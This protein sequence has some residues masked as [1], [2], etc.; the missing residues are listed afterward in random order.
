MS[1]RTS[2][3]SGHQYK[4]VLVTGMTTSSWV[5]VTLGTYKSGYSVAAAISYAGKFRMYLNKSATS[6]MYF[7]YI[8]IN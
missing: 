1:G 8:V 5:L 3:T 7:S 6:T 2:I 4:D